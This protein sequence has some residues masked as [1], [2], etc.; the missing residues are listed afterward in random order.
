[1]QQCFTLARKGAGNVSPNPMV[2]AVIVKNGRKIGEGYHRRYGGPHAEVNAIRY[3]LKRKHDLAGAT[4]YV[5]LEPCSHYGKTPPCVEAI[6]KHGF[7]RVVIGSIDPNPL[8]AGRGIR[9]LREHGIQ[10]TVGVSANEA[11][12]LNESF[13]KFIQTNMPFVAI[14]AAQTSD[15]FIA[16]E[17]GSSKW[18]TNSKS[19]AFGHQLRSQYDAVLVG[20]HTVMMDNPE[21]TV[22]MV[23]GRNPVR[24]ILDGKFS[25]PIHSKIYQSDA[26]TILYTDRKFAK[27]HQ[28]KLS[29]LRVVGIDVVELKGAEG[30][31][32][33]RQILKDL[34]RRNIASVL[35]EGGQRSYAAFL[36]AKCVDKIWLFTSPKKFQRGVKTFNGISVS[37]RR[38]RRQMKRFS[39][40]TLC[41]YDIT[42]R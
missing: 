5:N 26:P 13:F 31:L 20:A 7:Q 39:T 33:I 22:R 15:G 19:R 32:N 41:E 10:C 25:T 17:D 30:K 38:S 37:Y 40:N 23:K 42:F 29:A 6:I 16:R 24:I 21:L 12:R 8:V 14:K 18:I 11:K 35:V 36:N 4:I 27:E 28:K 2:G 9:N 34:G 1:M 3:A